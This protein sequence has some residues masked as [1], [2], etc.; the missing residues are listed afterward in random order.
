MAGIGFSCREN[1][2]ATARVATHA[3][4]SIREPMGTFLRAE[5][6]SVL[7]RNRIE[8]SLL[9]VGV[10]GKVV[11]LQGVLR[12]TNGLPELTQEALEGLEREIRRIPGVQRVEM[13]LS[14]WQRQNSEWR[15]MGSPVLET[16]ET[17]ELDPEAAPTQVA[18]SQS[19]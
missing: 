3:S 9:R 5:T 18:S 13:L 12:R 16:V 19:A 8:V 7:S 14:N 1:A 6:R 4:S 10:F 15:S 2:D 11:R 17:V